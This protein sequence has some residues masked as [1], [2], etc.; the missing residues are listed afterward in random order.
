MLV[1]IQGAVVRTHSDCQSKGMVG[2]GVGIPVTDHQE[3]AVC[4]GGGF[5]EVEGEASTFMEA[6][7][8]RTKAPNGLSH[9]HHHHWPPIEEFIYGDPGKRDVLKQKYN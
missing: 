8:K 2:M 3:T 6:A 4:E 1:P 5:L 9:S 7:T